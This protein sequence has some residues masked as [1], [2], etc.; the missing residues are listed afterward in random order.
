MSALPGI[1]FALLLSLTVN[2]QDEM[3]TE[4]KP[5]S[6]PS[7]PSPS[8]T[9]APKA[10]TKPIDPGLRAQVRKAAPFWIEDA[11]RGAPIRVNKDGTFTSAAQGGGSIAGSWKAHKGELHI[12]WSGGGEQYSYAAK[13]PKGRLQLEG[14]SKKKNRFHLGGG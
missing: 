1:L 13:A 2:A 9:T 4:I 14:K 5:D 3:Q 11:E 7:V 6:V 12:Q 10:A 8:P